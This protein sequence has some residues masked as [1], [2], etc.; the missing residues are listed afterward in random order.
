MKCDV[1]IIGGGPAGSTTASLLRKYDPTLKVVILE[2]EKFPRD[3]VGESQLPAIMRILDEMGVWDKVEAADFPV[4]IGGTYR[5][6]RTDELWDFEFIPGE[7]Y[8]DPPRPAK[9]EGQRTVT[10]WQVDRPIYDQ[11]LLDHAASMGTTVL[12][13]TQVRKVRLDGDRVLGFELESVNKDNPTVP[14]GTVLEAD[15]YVDCSG[16]TGIIR[17]S[18]GIEIEAPTKLRNLAF[19][20][21]WT[22]AEWAV[23]I[24]NGGTRI[25]IMSLG[26]GWMWCIP[27]SKTKSSIG[28]VVPGEYFK[29]S[30]KTS[31]ELY[32]EAMRTEPLISHLTRNATREGR[33]RAMK[34][35][36]FLAERLAGENWL[37]AG[38]SC[39]FADPILSAGMTLAHTSGR[40]AAYTI[41]ELRKGK[42]DP[43]WLKEQFSEGHRDQIRHHMQFA[44]YWY[45]ANGRFTDLREYCSEIAA[46]AGFTLGAEDAF[47]WLAA[48]GFALE[49][50]GLARAASYRV[51]SI[52][53][54]T[55][56]FSGDHSG[57]EI[58]KNN[59][60]KLNLE[61][62]TKEKHAIYQDGKIAMIDRFRRGNK[63]LPIHYVYWLIYNA[64]QRT[65]DLE[66]MMKMC[67]EVAKGNRMFSKQSEAYGHI[68]E[69]LEALIVEGWITASHNPARPLLPFVVPTESASMHPN[70]DNVVPS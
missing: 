57:Y 67:M 25:Q 18:M 5:W 49:D 46:S 38:D 9:F 62:A 45:S 7:K 26:W 30:G 23:T 3:H 31:E 2:R 41:L 59:V 4:K 12:E 40:K 58:A 29:N 47:R 20:D 15:Y 63:I 66:T 10:A 27:I 8:E 65:S 42:L 44:D 50:P 22:D 33:I 70:R 64:L 39:G 24:G 60:L 21:Y 19:W 53:F 13:E 61:G 48:G 1:A 51:A 55:N 14:E 52:K 28:L 69:G 16:E 43:K 17:R 68:M 11:I 35:W 36:N 37:M 32:M 34:D 54:I 6:G 56:L